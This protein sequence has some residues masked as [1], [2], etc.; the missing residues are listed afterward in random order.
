MELKEIEYIL[1]ISDFGSISKAS[2]ALYIAQPSLSK[3]LSKME[4]K[5]GTKL[6]EREKEG[7]KATEAGDIYIQYARKIKALV[8]ICDMKIA[9]VVENKKRKIVA[10]ITLN[11]SI[12]NMSELQEKFECIYPGYELQIDQIMYKDIA[13]LLSSG[14]LDIAFGDMVNDP[15]IICQELYK[16]RMLLAVNR[17]YDRKKLRICSEK[18]DEFPYPWVDITQ[19]ENVNLILQEKECRIHQH[20]KEVAGELL[21]RCRKKMLVV[22]S[23]IAIHA[24]ELQPGIC[25]LS[26]DFLDF[27]SH[28]NCVNI[29][30]VGEQDYYTKFYAITNKEKKVGSMEYFVM[31]AIRNQMNRK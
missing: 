15:D 28:R 4:D 29:Y 12:L 27:I 17:E 24:V 23:V 18:R 31:D 22:N 9:D 1:A 3:Y 26:E 13:K 8:N 19:L 30:S 7:M 25:F 11:T 20:I 21:N 14:L 10:G 5:I 2:E 16:G 6:F